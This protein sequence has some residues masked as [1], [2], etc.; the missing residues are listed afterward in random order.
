MI[1]TIV[2]RDG[3]TEPFSPVKINGWAEFAA[4]HLGG[5]VDWASIAMRA[6]AKLPEVTN[7]QDLQLALIRECLDQ[8]SW[9]YYRM[10]AK[11]YVPYS[12]KKMYGSDESLP[13]VKDVQM[14]MAKWS[15]MRELDYSDAEY[16]EI[17]EIIHHKRDFNYAYFQIKQI[18]E[19]YS[20]HD[21]RKDSESEILGRFFEMPQYVYMRMA[22]ALAED[23][24]RDMRMH[25]LKKW[26]DHFSNNRLN[27][28]TPNFVNLG[29]THNGY[30][31]CCLYVTDDT[32]KSLGIG[33]H[34]ARTM[35]VASAGIGGALIC[36][37]INDPVRGGLIVHQGKVP[38]YNA[39]AGAVNSSVQNGRGGACT[40]Y[41]SVYDP[42]VVTLMNLRHP[43]SPEEKKI[44]TMDF[45]VCL[46]KHIVRKAC[47]NED[48]FLFNVHT[49]PDL[50]RA[51]YD[52]EPGLFEA[53]YA[54]YEADPKFKKTY[55]SA[56][57]LMVSAVNIS[58]ETGSLYLFFADEVNRHTPFYDTIYSSNLCVA[59]ET[60]IRTKTGDTP[61]ESLQ[62]RKVEV[63]NGE[64]WSKVTVRKTGTNRKLLR[65]HV[66]DGRV[67]NCTK[68]HK[69]FV[70]RTD[71]DVVETMTLDLKPGDQLESWTDHNGNEFN[72]YIVSIQDHGRV[73][74]TFCV[75]EPLRHR[76]VF[77]GILTGNCAEITEPTAPYHDMVDLYTAGPVGH[78]RIKATLLNSLK[79]EDDVNVGTVFDHRF[80]APEP[81]TMLKSKRP[82]KA[83]QELQ[84]GDQFMTERGTWEVSELTDIKIEP[85][86]A[87]CSLAAIVPSYIESEEQYAEVAYYALKMIDKCIHMSD[88]PLAHIGYTARQRLSAG[89]GLT[90][91][92][93]YMAKKRLKYSTVEGKQELH[94]LAE[95]HAY[96]VINASLR[97]GKELG[98][99]P[100][101]HR[102]KWPEG[103]LP[104][105]TYEKRVDTIA[106]FKLEQD[107]EGLRVRIIE[108]GG[109]RNSTLISHMPT[110]SSSKASGI[111][112]GYYPIREHALAKTDNNLK[113]DWAPTEGDRLKRHYEIAWDIPYRDMIECYAILQKFTDQAISAD[114]WVRL[115][116][117]SEVYSEQL[118]D[119]SVLMA[120]YGIKTRYYFNSKTSQTIVDERT[121]ESHV[122]EVTVEHNVSDKCVSGGCDA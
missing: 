26:Y 65:V 23:E 108:N 104:I 112:N 81:I 7:S 60:L 46:N 99:A 10:A 59:P 119:S 5:F 82:R 118:L 110:E 33:D 49:A 38:Y 44:L 1:T 55:V 79:D 20:L 70:E 40:T 29:T 28:P 24:P 32:E 122:V 90:G 57:E 43:K 102:T 51:F 25:H 94:R 67:L 106:E 9:A 56:R 92:A 31:S 8:K 114:Q 61:I 103:W 39:L 73:S 47:D 41:F 107:W 115:E 13:S 121:G 117:D 100:W 36:R 17:E 111:P 14:E 35:T 2:K 42:E 116:G 21:R 120:R 72:D 12:R 64:Q 80:S 11:L 37:S 96:H 22:M 75:T 93:H 88:F 89:V 113:L 34:I 68:E 53:L 45:A 71:G 30:A 101:I 85:E 27:A 95:R 62:D 77:N 86:V 105:D 18:I 19:K 97:L 54:K 3:T 16:A 4:K 83:A 69:W 48:V 91:V 50:V 15:L 87:L 52:S 74:D 76:V 58:I 63:W 78:A 109:I 98:N 6:V 84:I 66:S